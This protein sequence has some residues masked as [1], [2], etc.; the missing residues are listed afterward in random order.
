MEKTQS[1]SDQMIDIM[2]SQRQQSYYFLFGKEIC[3]IYFE[4]GIEAVRNEME[5]GSVPYFIFHKIDTNPADLLGKFIGWGDYAELTK[6]EY[7][8]IK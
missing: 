8:R 5:N 2:N 7:E 1:H 3:S 6:T 4:Y